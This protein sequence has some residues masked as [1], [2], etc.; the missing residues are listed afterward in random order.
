[1]ASTRTIRRATPTARSSTRVKQTGGRLPACPTAHTLRCQPQRAS[2][3][4]ALRLDHPTLRPFGVFTAVCCCAVV[5]QHKHD[6][7]LPGLAQRRHHTI[8]RIPSFAIS[9][10]SAATAVAPTLDDAPWLHC[11]VVHVPVV[12]W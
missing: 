7:H 12:H 9:A 3:S 8:L 10:L 11:G 5:L 4:R 2:A 1:L 6:R